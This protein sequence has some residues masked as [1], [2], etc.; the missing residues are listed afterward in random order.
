MFKNQLKFYRSTLKLKQED[1][2]QQIGVT[3]QC[4]AHYEQGIREPS[5]D[6]IRKLCVVFN[7]TA[8]ELLGLDSE[9]KRKEIAS[10]L[11]K[12]VKQ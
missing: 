2:A 11:N 12:N 4:Y 9:S 3:R 7:C 1:V 6:M 8:D 5:I 10:K